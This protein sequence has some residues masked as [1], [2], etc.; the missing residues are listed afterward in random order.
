MPQPLSHA[1]M[2]WH[3][4]R[5]Q[6]ERE[7]DAAR[8]ALDAATTDTDR[9]ALQARLHAAEH[10]IQALGPAPDAKMG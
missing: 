3:V 5:H 6:H 8:T 4:R 9:A 1:V 7:R 2:Q 10:R